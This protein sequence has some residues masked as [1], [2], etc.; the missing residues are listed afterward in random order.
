[1][2]IKQGKTWKSLEFLLGFWMD[3]W[4][5]FYL[6]YISLLHFFNLFVFPEAWIKLKLCLCWKFAGV[7]TEIHIKSHGALECRINLS[8]HFRLICVVYGRFS[9]FFFTF[10]L[11]SLRTRRPVISLS[12]LSVHTHP[13]A[14]VDNCLPQVFSEAL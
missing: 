11:F 5:T 4:I 13:F 10:E 2:W 8:L 6:L 9:S 14:L 3:L 12:L 7:F 1:M